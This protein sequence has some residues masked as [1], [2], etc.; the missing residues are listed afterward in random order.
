MKK[1]SAFLLLLAFPA[2]LWAFTPP[3]PGTSFVYPSPVPYGACPNV[4][5]N[6]A[7][8]GTVRVLI[9]SESGD[10]IDTVTE[11]KPAGVQ[12]SQF[13]TY[14]Y[15]AGVYFYRLILTYDSGTQEKLPV[16]RFLLVH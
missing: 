2:L 16:G 12:Q 9:Y 11:T 1:I 8:P 15:A 7:G 5:Y 4:A 13:C 10:L 6:M 14:T 3:D